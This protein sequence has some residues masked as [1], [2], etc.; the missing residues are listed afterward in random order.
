MFRRRKVGIN[1][2]DARILY[3]WQDLQLQAVPCSPPGVVHVQ[4]GVEACENSDMS[5]MEKLVSGFML[6]CQLSWSLGRG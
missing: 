4:R 3:E 6:C 2:A 5:L 1:I